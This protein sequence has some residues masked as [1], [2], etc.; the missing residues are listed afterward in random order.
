M[1]SLRFSEVM[2]IVN[3]T[4]DSFYSATRTLDIDAAITRGQTLFEEGAGI[5]DVGG[6]STRP[7]ATPVP[8]DEE[9]KRVVPVVKELARLGTVSIDTMKSEV[10]QA[11]IDVGASIVNDVSGTLAAVAGANGVA[12]IA[13]HAQGTPE[14][15]QNDPHYGDLV[16]EITEWFEEKAHQAQEA[17]IAQWWLDPGIGFGKT[18]EHNLSILRHCEEF[19]GVAHRLGA[20]LLMGTS[21]KGFLGT[22]GNSDALGVN[23]RLAPSLASAI[24]AL[25]AGADI[26]RVHDVLPT[27]QAVRILRENM[28]S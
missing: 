19:A 13:M 2:G 25:E 1:T 14:T 26:V 24:I 10:A 9:L 18:V 28:S 4:P 20:G 16:G 5:V 6:E 22:M 11:S 23:E 3:V 7:G 17:N 12:W 8:L 27:V 15:M 21:R